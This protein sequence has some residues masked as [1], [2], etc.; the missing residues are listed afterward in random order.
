MDSTNLL[1]IQAFIGIIFIGGIASFIIIKLERG[2]TNRMVQL[3][4]KL[5]LRHN[6]SVLRKK[7]SRYPYLSFRYKDIEVIVDYE[8]GRGKS[9]APYTQVCIKSPTHRNCKIHLCRD[10]RVAT[11]GKDLSAKRIKLYNPEFDNK[12]FVSTDDENFARSIISSSI[13][14][15]L[16]EYRIYDIKFEFKKDNLVAAIEKILESESG[17]S[18]L[19]DVTLAIYDRLKELN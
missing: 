2:K 10:S 5:A 1:L 15:K 3:F 19:T 13:Q 18:E 11:F 16:L 8:Y 12:L 4:D 9:Y 17:F 7:K 14:T 6:G